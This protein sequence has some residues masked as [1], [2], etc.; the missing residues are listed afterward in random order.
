MLPFL[1]RQLRL[2]LEKR[3]PSL[4]T[5]TLIDDNWEVTVVRVAR[6]ADL[7]THTNFICFFPKINRN[8][9]FTS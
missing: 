3:F 4:G 8:A 7:R 6:Q 9:E 2:A 1:E 5:Y